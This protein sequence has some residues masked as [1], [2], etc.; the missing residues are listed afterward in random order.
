M[1]TCCAQSIMD[2]D[3]DLDHINYYPKKEKK[4]AR[5]FRCKHC[6]TGYTTTG[7]D[8]PPTPKW[9]D[10]HVCELVEVESKLGDKS[11]PGII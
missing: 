1:I 4:M 3:R 8:V 11:P 10:G 2:L 5:A 6:G 7:N 9:A